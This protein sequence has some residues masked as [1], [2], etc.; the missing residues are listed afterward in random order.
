[1]A[2]HRVRRL[3]RVMTEVG[4][5]TALFS[6]GPDLYYLTGHSG[7]VSERLTMLGVPAIGEP[8][9]VVPRLEA[10]LVPEGGLEL[11][12]WDET[13]DPVG[14]VAARCRNARRVAIGDHTW[15]VFLVGLMS[16]LADVKWS[17]GSDL[18]RRL[19]V[20]KDESELAALASAG[21][22]MDRALDRVPDEIRFQG[23]SEAEVAGDLRRLTV[24]EGHDTAE[25]AIVASGPNGA[26]PHHSPGERLIETGD[27]V[28]CDFGGSLDGYQSDVTRTFTVGDPS[29]EAIEV[30]EVVREANRAGRRAAAPGVPC[31]EVD[32]AAREVI[33]RAGLGE[34]FIHRTGHGI[35]IEVHEHPYLVEGNTEMLAAGMTFSVEPGV[36]LPGRF[37]VRIEDIVACTESGLTELNQA[38]RGL[39][40]VS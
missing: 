19:R 3:Q 9:L 24:E 20:I 6:T 34:H 12:V 15:S 22:A 26:S 35:G 14:L 29:P 28:V 33:E 32:R 38:D 21:A 13:T 23:R 25:F 17:V 31:Q 39:I 8:W 4:I 11:M 36:Y 37:G 10:P 2:E 5:D 1:M 40:V 30:H 7:R 16:R 18:T 27:V